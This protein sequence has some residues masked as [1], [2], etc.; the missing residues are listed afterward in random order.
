MDEIR[1]DSRMLTPEEMSEGGATGTGVVQIE[2][3]DALYGGV[4]PTGKGVVR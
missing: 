1:V 4:R 2:P 3:D